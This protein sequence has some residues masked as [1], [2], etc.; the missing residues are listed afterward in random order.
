ML[1]YKKKLTTLT[2][3]CHSDR[4]SEFKKCEKINFVLILKSTLILTV[5]SFLKLDP[6]VLFPEA[7]RIIL[8]KM[9]AAAIL[10]TQVRNKIF[11]KVLPV[12][13]QSAHGKISTYL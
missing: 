4:P 12:F 10:D 6:H 9:P 11:H 13:I 1:S 5:V 7:L 8:S 3:E 2:L